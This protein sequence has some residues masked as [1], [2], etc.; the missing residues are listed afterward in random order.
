MLVD[1]FKIVNYAGG[2][3]RVLCNFANE[4]VKRNYQIVLVGLD[5]EKGVP[6]FELDSKV[7]FI[8]LCYDVPGKPYICAAYYW[9]KAKKEILR[10]IGGPELIIHDKKRRDPKK[11]YF[12]NNFVRRLNIAV[13]QEQPD[14][15]ID[16]GSFIAAIVNKAI[17][18][19]PSIAHISMCHTDAHRCVKE[20]SVEEVNAWKKCNVVQVLMPSYIDPVKNIGIHNVIYIPNTV[21]QIAK[22]NTTDLKTCHHTII[23]VGRVEEVQKRQHLL[24]Q[25]F[26]KIADTYPDWKVKIYGQIDNNGYTKELQTFISLHHLEEKV[27]FCGTTKEI[28]KCLAQADIFAFPSASEGF[29]LALTEAMT[30]GLPSIGYRSCNAVNELIKDGE[31]GFLCEDGIDDFAIKLETLI[32]NQELRIKMGAKAHEDMKEYAPSKIWDMW[33]KVICKYTGI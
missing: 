23:N 33:E 3:E 5:T 24:I 14:I 17:Q 20:I 16:V 10:A 27:I 26:A 9:Q 11:E 1:E 21:P 6:A 7:K 19:F 18:E 25:A 13:Q 4:F 30:M 31:N 12:K 2:I 15:I 28:R 22:E 32:K 29:G 8:N